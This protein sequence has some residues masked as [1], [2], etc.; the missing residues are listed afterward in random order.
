MEKETISNMKEGARI[1]KAWPTLALCLYFKQE[2]PAQHHK[3]LFR[4]A[5]HSS[6]QP[7]FSTCDKQSLKLPTSA[8]KLRFK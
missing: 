3:L 5:A 4:F 1:L 2:S 8:E 7:D 6:Y